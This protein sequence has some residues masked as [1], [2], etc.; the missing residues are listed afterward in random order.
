MRYRILADLVV[1][2]HFCFIAF[3]IVGGALVLWRRRVMVAHLPAVAWGIFIELSH[4]IC[5]LTPLENHY[6][7]LGGEAGYAGG[8][9]DHYV[10]GIIYPEGLT[11]GMQVGIACLII[12]INAVCYGLVI[13]LW[14]QSRRRKKMRQPL[15]PA[16]ADGGPDAG[17]A[18]EAPAGEDGTPNGEV[19]VSVTGGQAVESHGQ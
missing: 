17:R 10:A 11:P 4:G 18:W 3:V 19:A 9:V 6:R 2:F 14:S 8:F 12:G 13:W 16:P 7:D 1:I 5:P 15:V